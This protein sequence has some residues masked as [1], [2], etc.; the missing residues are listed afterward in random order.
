MRCI[1]W[2]QPQV[3]FGLVADSRRGRCAGS[4]WRLGLLVAAAGARLQRLDL[5]GHGRQVGVQRLVQQALLL[6]AEGLAL[7]GELQPLE[8][9]FSCVSLSMTACLKATRHAPRSIRRS[10]SASAVSSESAAITSWHRA[11]AESS[12]IG[13]CRN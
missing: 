13:V 6:G 4:G 7:G 11:E 8:H 5:G 9:A 2:P 3:V 1:G 12:A 10:C